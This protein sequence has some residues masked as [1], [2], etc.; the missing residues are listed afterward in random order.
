MVFLWSHGLG[1]FVALCQHVAVFAHSCWKLEL[2]PLLASAWA[3]E[4]VD[5]E[6]GKFGIVE[7]EV[8][9]AVGVFVQKVC[10]CPVKYR[11]EVV[12]DAVDTFGG[13][14]AELLLVNLYLLVAVGTSVF[15]GLYHWEALYHTPTHAVALNVGLQVVDCFPCQHLA[16]R[17]LVEG[18]HDAFH[19]NL[20]EH[21]K[22]DLVFLAKPSPCSFHYY[23]FEVVTF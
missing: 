2:R 23:S 1:E 15:D 16:K 14:V 13:E 22:C 20:F 21:G 9:G 17:H 11:H 10:A 7:V 8:G 12:A 6:I 19:T 5:V 18:C 4:D 3:F